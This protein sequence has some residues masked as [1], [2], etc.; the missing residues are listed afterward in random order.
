MVI[1]ISF[2]LTDF[3]FLTGC[4][5]SLFPLLLQSF[6]P[7]GVTCP[8]NAL[9]FGLA[10]RLWVQIVANFL[11]RLLLLYW[12]AVIVGPEVLSN[13]SDLISLTPVKAR[14]HS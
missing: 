4:L 6:H 9:F 1:L 8:L 5:L 10:V 11:I 14:R 3:F 12:Y 2:L 13:D 7:F